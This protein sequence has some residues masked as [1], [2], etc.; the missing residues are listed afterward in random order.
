M[1]KF[2]LLLIGF[3]A[4]AVGLNARTYSYAFKNGD[5]TTAPATVS[6]GSISYAQNEEM[7]SSDI[8]WTTTKATE[9]KWD[10]SNGRG[11][12]IG[13]SKSVCKNFSLTTNTFAEISSEIRIKS[14]SVYS[15]VGFEDIGTKL[16][17]KVGDKSEEFLLTMDKESKYTLECDCNGKI[18]L[19]WEATQKAYY[20]SKIEVVYV[21]PASMVNVELPVFKT[22]TDSIY[23]D[24][25]QVTVET[26]D[27]IHDIYYTLDGTVPSYE[28]YNS[29]PRVGTTGCSK[30]HQM[31]FN[32]VDTTT[33]NNIKVIAVQVDEGV[34]YKREEVIEATYIVSPTKPYIHVTE[35]TNGNKY[36][37]VANDSVA[38]ALVPSI[39]KGFLSDRKTIKHEK[40]I[41]TIE[42]DAFTFTEIEGGY[43]IQDAAG[44]YMY[45][46]ENANEFSF[47][48]EK[49]ETGAV[50]SIAFN[51]NK[52]EITNGNKTIYYVSDKGIFGCYEEAGENMVL[53][54]LYTPKEY[55]QIVFDPENGSEVKGLQVIIVTCKD[56]ISVSNNFK[57][58][59]RG[60]QYGNGIYEIN[61]TYKHEQLNENTLKF[62]IDN[63]LVSK[64]NI[65]LDIV[66]EGD[67]YLNPDV[68]KYPLQ[69]AR[70]TNKICSYKHL[71]DAEPAKIT[72][73]EPTD[74]STVEELKY[75]LFTFDNYV[76]EVNGEK[77]AKLHLEGSEELIELEYTT[78][79]YGSDSEHIDQLQGALKTAE[80]I[81]ANGTYILEIGDGYFK[82]S[83]GNEVKGTTLKYIVKN[84]LTSVEEI[85]TKEENGCVVY[86][87]AG[88]KVLDTTNANDLNT[89]R[90]GIYIINGQKRLI[91]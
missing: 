77:G 7:V 41:E 23:A 4:F 24:N 55:P 60:N 79:K 6:L 18:E 87:V 45:I 68:L 31:I 76:T 73:V 28:D 22:P 43:T 8:V 72:K 65:E 10:A 33:V 11:F 17:I 53:P 86:N 83:N 62:T 46:A 2:L 78:Y 27:T 90:K 64:N 51:E 14:V 56:G 85:T 81:V 80:P 74:N 34:V 66:I 39:N 42:Y 26:T 19:N 5:L 20:L 91:K 48:T 59:A 1:K 58:I 70:Y 61:A 29:D 12:Q 50:W 16:T 69:K 21:L 84:D 54:E 49:P 13:S 36:A 38:D 89:L 44:R 35:I 82:D 15:C 67:I 52:A 32:L 71:G 63:P 40:C 37:F 88:I 9:M 47:A 57:L 30:G 75:F 25:V 3:M